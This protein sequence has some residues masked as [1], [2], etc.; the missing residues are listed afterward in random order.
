MQEIIFSR[1]VDGYRTSGSKEDQA[2]LADYENFLCFPHPMLANKGN[3][4]ACHK[5]V[6]RLKK[7]EGEG[8]NSNDIKT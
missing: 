1:I 2:F 4:Y 8:A 7:R 6:G 3:T 5:M